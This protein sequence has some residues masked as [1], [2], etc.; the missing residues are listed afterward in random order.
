M[1][2]LELNRIDMAFISC[3]GLDPA[4]GLSD[5][6]EEQAELKRQ[7]VL[8]ASEVVLL[9]DHTRGRLVLEFFFAKN[10]DVD[11]WITDSPAR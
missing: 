6:T 1:Q 5:A 8:R 9:A 2:G 10:A 4:L 3:R 11:F 7:V